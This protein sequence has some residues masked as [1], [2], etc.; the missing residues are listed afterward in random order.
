M[1]YRK[2]RD[3]QNDDGMYTVLNLEPQ[4]A[5]QSHLIGLYE[6]PLYRF[7]YTFFTLISLAL[8]RICTIV[9]I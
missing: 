2:A 5:Q 3:R 4:Y 1:P 9:N 8:Y 6:E 7:L